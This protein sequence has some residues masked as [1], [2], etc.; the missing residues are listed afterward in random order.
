MLPLKADK[1]KCVEAFRRFTQA[2]RQ[3]VMGALAQLHRLEHLTRFA[4]ADEVA[5]ALGRALDDR[6][7]VQAGQGAGGAGPRRGAQLAGLVS[8]HRA[9]PA[10]TGPVADQRLTNGGAAGSGP[11][12]IAVTVPEIPRLLVRLPWARPARRP[13]AARSSPGPAGVAATNASPKHAIADAA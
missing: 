13:P 11:V 6:R 4:E 5:E 12:P 7:P 2:E 3:R 8:P 9:R 1:R 10:G